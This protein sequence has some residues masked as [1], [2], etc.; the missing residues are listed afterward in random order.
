MQVDK[1]NGN[2]MSFPCQPIKPDNNQLLPKADLK[3]DEFVKTTNDNQWENFV[4]DQY[5]KQEEVY[6]PIKA[7]EEER[8]KNEQM[9][10]AL[11]V[12]PGK[13]T[14]TNKNVSFD[15]KA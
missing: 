5:K 10:K 2:T 7:M 12:R 13:F 9:F 15:R 14:K 6:D 4:V 8:I 11:V 1:V 3:S